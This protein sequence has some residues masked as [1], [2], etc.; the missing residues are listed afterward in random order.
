M[1]PLAVSLDSSPEP[2]CVADSA[3]TRSEDTLRLSVYPQFVRPL[4]HLSRCPRVPGDFTSYTTDMEPEP[5]VFLVGAERYQLQPDGQGVRVVGTDA[6]PFAIPVDTGLHL[7]RLTF[8]RFDDD[9]VFLY[10][11]TDN[12]VGTSRVARLDNAS[13]RVK[14]VSKVP[15]FNLGYALRDGSH[16]YVTCIGFVGKLDLTDGR[17][18]WRHDN[19][20]QTERFNDFRPPRL[21]G[22]TV[23]FPAGRRRLPVDR[24]TGRRFDR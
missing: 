4:E 7:E 16:L 19:L 21:A 13:L 14:W 20:Y 15:G 1:A 5:F 12:E 9:P 22:D 17:Y 10:Q 3:H 11:I 8:T 18:L 24:Q 6:M 2:P 23:F